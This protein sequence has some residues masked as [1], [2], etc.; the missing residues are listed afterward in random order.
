MSDTH[1]DRLAADGISVEFNP[2]GGNLWNFSVRTVDGNWI[3]PLH[4][5]RWAQQAST[6]EKDIP[7]VERQL[8]GDFFCAPFGGG[9][10]API[11]GW[12]ANGHWQSIGIE[13]P[14]QESV[15]H[16]YKLAETVNSA[17]VTKTLSL[18]ADHPFLYQ[19]H[20]FKG[21]SC[22]LPIAHHAMIHAPGGAKLSFSKRDF[23]VTPNSPLESDTTR[24]H[25][26]LLYPQTFDRLDQV[27]NKDG[28]LLDLSQYPCAD[29]HEDLVVLAGDKEATT[30]WSAAVAKRDGFLFLAIK[31]AQVLPET[32]LWMSNGGRFYPPWNSE[33]TAVLGIEEAATACHSTQQF[34]SL[35]EPSS[36]GLAAGLTLSADNT[37]DIRYCFGAMAVPDGW[38]EVAS[39][40]IL[41]D[42]VRVTDITGG[43]VNLPFDGKFFG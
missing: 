39:V 2:E 26:M 30:A 7:L 20:R 4:T 24:G 38:S 21:G 36:H 37:C 3:H 41:A 15:A 29:A 22:H 18:I 5:A 31:D 32:V 19:T 23:G 11:H 25:S 34:D 17:V 27:R 42:S 33:H 12:T 10:D 9:G 28:D 8:S 1:Y 6:L 40:D 16:Q 13:Q 35:P 14:T 43:A